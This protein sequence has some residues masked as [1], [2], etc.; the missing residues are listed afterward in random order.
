MK[1]T[2]L[3]SGVVFICFFANAQWIDS[4]I[5]VVNREIDRNVVSRDLAAL[6]KA[7]A[8]D[9]VFSHGSG[10]VEGKKSWLASVAKSNFLKREHDSVT[11]EMHKNIAI[12]KGKLSVRKQTKEKI[13]S[14]HL[15][16][17]RVYRKEKDWQMISHNTYWEIHD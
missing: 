13:D 7:Y 8:E 16:Y 3:T 9:F 6:E 1:R 10:K 12:V 4:S 14:Y 2:L 11:V 15:K 5:W 17:I